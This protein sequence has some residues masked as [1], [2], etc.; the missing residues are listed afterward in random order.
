MPSFSEYFIAV[1]GFSYVVSLPIPLM[2]PRG[3]QDRA[4]IFTA[5]LQL[6]TRSPERLSGLFKAT[7]SLCS[8]WAWNLDLTDALLARFLSVFIF[9]LHHHLWVQ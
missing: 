5:I 4:D 9:C 7:I 2:V 1:K 8:G 3:R 6:R